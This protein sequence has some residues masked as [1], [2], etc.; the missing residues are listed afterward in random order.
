[1]YNARQEYARQFRSTGNHQERHPKMHRE[2]L[3]ER[4]LIRW[5]AGLHTYHQL[6][7]TAVGCGLTVVPVLESNN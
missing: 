4:V 7:A 2:A 1:M 3:A 5:L 6:G